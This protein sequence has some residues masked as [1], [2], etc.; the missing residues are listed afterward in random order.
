MLDWD[1]TMSWSAIEDL[2]RAR[3][4]VSWKCFG[5]VCSLSRNGHTSDKRLVKSILEVLLTTWTLHIDTLLLDIALCLLADSRSTWIHRTTPHLKLFSLLHFDQ[6]NYRPSRET[7]VSPKPDSSVRDTAM[8]LLSATT[9]VWVKS[10]ST[11]QSTNHTL[12]RCILRR[13]N[14]MK[15]GQGKACPHRR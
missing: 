10:V 3:C 11:L 14:R 4:M 7:L 6:R 15:T 9:V 12:W 1:I 2:K 13:L 8:L 5:S